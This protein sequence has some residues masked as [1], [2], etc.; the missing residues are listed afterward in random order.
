MLKGLFSNDVEILRR[1][2]KQEKDLPQCFACWPRVFKTRCVFAYDHRQ[3]VNTTRLDILQNLYLNYA[4][5]Y[6]PVLLQLKQQKSLLQNHFKYV[7]INFSSDKFFQL[8]SILH[9]K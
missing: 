7:L 2:D 1:E 4:I 5:T 9:S 6:F 8:S 3:D